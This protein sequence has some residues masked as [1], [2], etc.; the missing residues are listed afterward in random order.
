MW[1]D[2]KKYEIPTEHLIP[3][4]SNIDTYGLK[5]ELKQVDLI[6]III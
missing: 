5:N 6:Q 4:A 2:L 3:C 1:K